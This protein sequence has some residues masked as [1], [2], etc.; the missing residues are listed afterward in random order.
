[1][2]GGSGHRK[3][4]LSGWVLQFPWSGY[5]RSKGLW[6]FQRLWAILKNWTVG[7]ILLHGGYNFYHQLSR[8]AR[9]HICRAIAADTSAVKRQ[10]YSA[11]IWIGIKRCGRGWILILIP[12]WDVSLPCQ[13]T[14][15]RN[16]FFLTD[17]LMAIPG[18]SLILL[19]WCFYGDTHCR[20]RW[21][22]PWMKTSRWLIGTRYPS[23]SVQVV[24]GWT[25]AETAK[26]Y[27]YDHRPFW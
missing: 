9:Q 10:G 16:F 6:K 2:V 5:H 24:M 23:G 7:T 11:C 25:S 22:H 12:C 14:K 17:W 19:R 20:G 15:R 8:Q 27:P 1:M 3:L 4:L 21:G 18:F 13:R 26:P